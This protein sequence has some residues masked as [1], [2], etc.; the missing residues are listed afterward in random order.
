MDEP[1][2]NLDAKLRVQMR[3]EIKR[4]HQ[5][6][7]ATDHL[8]HARPA[9][10]GDHGRQDGGDE[11]RLP[12]AIR[13]ARR[14]SSPTRSTCSSPSFVGSPAMSLMPLEAV[15]ATATTSC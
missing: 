8:R 14:T 13:H 1:L 9:R 4:F 10:G 2:S 7:K 12:A 6:L 3:S 5:D 11:W 15:D